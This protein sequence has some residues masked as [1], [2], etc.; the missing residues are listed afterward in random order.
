MVAVE[1][2]VALRTELGLDPCCGILDE[3]VD[4]VVRLPEAVGARAKCPQVS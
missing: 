1:E 2:T 3:Q 4:V